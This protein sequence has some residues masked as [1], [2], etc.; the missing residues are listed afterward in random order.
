MVSIYNK[1]KKIC[2]ECNCYLIINYKFNN[3]ILIDSSSNN[4]ILGTNVFNFVK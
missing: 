1:E 4:V 3:F 2:Y